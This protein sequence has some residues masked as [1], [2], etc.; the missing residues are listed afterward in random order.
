MVTLREIALSDAPALYEFLSDPLVTAH[1][2]SPP[3]C[4]SS[5][6]GFVTWAQRERALGNGACFG[7]VPHGLDQAVG[8][9]Q[10]RAQDPTFFVAEWGFAV[11]APFWGTGVFAES[12]NLVARFAF[13]TLKVHRLE[14]RAVTNNG[15]GG[16][17]LQKLGA[18]PEAVLARAFKRPDRYDEQLLWTIIAS[19]WPLAPAEKF[20]ATAAKDRVRQAV[21]E[22]LGHLR[23][24]RAVIPRPLPALYPF[25]IT[26][27]A[28]RPMCPACGRV[29][30]PNHTCPS[31]RGAGPG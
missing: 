21:T 29:L 10:V 27:T 5:F 9:I 22:A 24:P 11:G 17:A 20:S 15:R 6:E 12:A 26:G 28:T 30:G 18:S 31:A 25:F 23:R 4:L 7:I 14:A 8:L 1:I 3:P 16:G 19:E 13:E 2:S